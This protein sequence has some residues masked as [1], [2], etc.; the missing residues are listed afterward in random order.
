MET[1]HKP[2]HLDKLGLLSWIMDIPK[3]SIQIV[4][5]FHEVFKYGNGAKF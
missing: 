4:I 3:R 1:T 2:L 5:L